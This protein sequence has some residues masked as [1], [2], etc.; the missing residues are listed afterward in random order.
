MTLKN[1]ALVALIGT[2]L[3]TVEICLQRETTAALPLLAGMAIGG[4]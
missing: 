2:I 1:A 4:E 3:M